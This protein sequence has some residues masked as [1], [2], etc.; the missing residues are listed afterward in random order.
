MQ[1]EHDEADYQLSIEQ[2]KNNFVSMQVKRQLYRGRPALALYIRD[3][4]K[5]VR[6]KLYRMIRQEQFQQS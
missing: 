1:K 5:R 4:T 6:E 2:L 3:K